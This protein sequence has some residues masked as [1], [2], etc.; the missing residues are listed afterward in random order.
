[1][2]LTSKRINYKNNIAKSLYST[3]IDNG[4]YGASN[5]V[6]DS[7]VLFS[8]RHGCSNN[9]IG[10]SEYPIIVAGSNNIIYDGSYIIATD[11][12]DCDI[13]FEMGSREPFVMPSLYHCKLRGSAYFI[14]AYDTQPVY[15]TE[16]N[17]VDKNFNSASKFS[18][19]QKSII[20][21]YSNEGGA[22]IQVNRNKQ[23]VFY[24]IDSD[25]EKTIY[26]FK[27]G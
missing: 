13:N 25:N 27:K 14:G 6:L 15:Y 5:N 22:W 24:L 17:G 21:V 8:G 9:T 19:P 23:G 18:L 12:Y 1:V 3:I 11:L 4:D 10:T 7:C 26:I 2:L 20:D 16:F